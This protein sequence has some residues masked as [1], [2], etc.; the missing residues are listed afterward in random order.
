MIFTDYI[1]SYKKI[2]VVVVFLIGWIPLYPVLR[3]YRGEV[4]TTQ[5]HINFISLSETLNYTSS[6][7]TVLHTQHSIRHLTSGQSHYS[8]EIVG[9]FT[10]EKPFS[11]NRTS[12]SS[13]DKR[14]ELY[15]I[16]FVFEGRC[17]GISSDMSLAVFFCDPTVKQAFYFSDGT[18]K[19]EELDL[20]I[21]LKTAFK[22][23]LVNCDQ[24]IRFTFQDNQL[25]EV[26]GRSKRKPRC[27]AAQGGRGPTRSPN[28]GA[29]VVVS[30]SC[31][32]GAAHVRLIEESWFLRDRSALR[33][34]PRDPSCDYPSCG[35]N[36]R[37]AMAKLLPQTDIKRCLNLSQ[38]VTVV[39]KT[40]R[41]PLLVLRL[42]QSIRNV[43]RQDIPIIVI[44]D[45]PDPHPQK[46]MK[47]IAEFPNMKYI[48]SQESDLGISEG[49]MRGVTMVTT[50]Y[51]VN[52]DDDNVV[53]KSW[54][55]AKMAELL[56]TTDLS[57]V[58]VKTDS[59]NW[60]AF[61]DFSYDNSGRRVL[62]HFD[63]S[64]R[65]ANQGL[66]FYPA[67]VRCD[68]TANSFMAK[69]DDVLE[70]GGWSLELMVHEH[71]DLFLRLKGAGKKVAWCPKFR[72]KN[73][74]TSFEGSVEEQEVYEELRYKRE[75]RMRKLMWNRWNFE[76]YKHVENE[77]NWSLSWLEDL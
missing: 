62:L 31:F 58:G 48:V 42:A 63:G 65:R 15:R 74:H 11:S 61:I 68:L 55:A 6:R 24:A 28:L 32:P 23:E 47:Q 2:V 27:I 69:R 67:C 64:C 16:Q 18:L 22:L 35:I 52:M 77:R 34:I 20:C 44:D 3:C 5:F 12:E 57:L 4:F 50:K 21:G 26:S 72:V 59:V 8:T 29:A 46:I 38:C 1:L 76:T 10:Q 70:V 9:G 60:P 19:S 53:T 14:D 73:V 7:Y 49:R 66:P 56:D 43:L 13:R 37:P 33:N 25:R 75:Q 45:G 71:Q 30:R 54:N 36:N 40:A 51:F 41:R 39:V 17:V